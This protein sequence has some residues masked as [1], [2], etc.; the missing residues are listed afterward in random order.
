ML[1]SQEIERNQI[2]SGFIQ[3]GGRSMLRER[4][5]LADAAVGMLSL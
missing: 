4:T 5:V 1:N 2:I 3:A